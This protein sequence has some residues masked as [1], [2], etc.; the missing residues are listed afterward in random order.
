M[1]E[2]LAAAL[3]SFEIDPDS[4]LSYATTLPILS[5]EA[6]VRF[7]RPLKNFK[8]NVVQDII[9][10]MRAT[11][12]GVISAGNLIQAIEGTRSVQFSTTMPTI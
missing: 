10:F 9:L 1:A 2:L 6:P 4:L 7:L 3:L 11:A 8:R 12:E 5:S